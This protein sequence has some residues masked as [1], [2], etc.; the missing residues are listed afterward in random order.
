MS[1]IN[2][3]PFPLIS[4]VIAFVI[5]AA[6]MGACVYGIGRIGLPD[7]VTLMIQIPLGALIYAG[8]SAVSKNESYLFL[9]SA[10]KHFRNGTAGN[11]APEE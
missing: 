5:V 8:L 11:T 4:A 9:L 6:L 10:L 7:W 3:I 1:M 2:K